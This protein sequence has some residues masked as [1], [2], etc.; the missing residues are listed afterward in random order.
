MP[1]VPNRAQGP[2]G[3]FEA[4]QLPKP[5]VRLRY[6]GSGVPAAAVSWAGPLQAS[7][8]LPTAEALQEG[9]DFLLRSDRRG[10]AAALRRALE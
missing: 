3:H 10:G 2:H 7:L 5:A 9:I 4:L 1:A 6:R 8:H